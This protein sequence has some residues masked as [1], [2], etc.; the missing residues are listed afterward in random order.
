MWSPS[1]SERKWERNRLYLTKSPRSS[2]FPCLA[3]RKMTDMIDSCQSCDFL[4]LYW[5]WNRKA[6]LALIG[7]CHDMNWHRI[8]VIIAMTRMCS[9]TVFS[10]AGTLLLLG[11]SLLPLDACIVTWLCFSPLKWSAG[12]PV[13]R[14]E[15][16]M[17]LCVG[18][19]RGSPAGREGVW[20][21]W[22]VSCWKF[23]KPKW[24]ISSAMPRSFLL[25]ILDSTYGPTGLLV[26]SI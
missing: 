25:H 15:K 12:S 13:D 7:V 21:R 24:L 6:R 9:C 20:D 23:R 22:W 5:N 14:G 19:L 8:R 18:W 3:E 26:T 2:F 16:E 11:A 10:A 17:S 1:S 4:L